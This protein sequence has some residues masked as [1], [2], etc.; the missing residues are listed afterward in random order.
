MGIKGIAIAT[1]S[2]QFIGMSYIIYKAYLTDLKQYLYL[3]CF[4]PKFN[5]IKELLIQGIPASLGMMMISLGIYIILYF[6]SMF[7]VFALAGYGTAIRF[8]QIFLLPILGLNAAVLSIAGQNFGAKNYERVEEVYNKALKYGCTIMFFAGILIYF[9]AETAVSLFTNDEEVIKY[10][11]T[12][13]QITALMEPIYPIFFI[14]NALLQGLKKATYV[15]F[16]SMFRMVILPL[17]TLSFLILYLKSSFDFVFWGLL[18]IN[19]IFGIF[20]FIFTKIVMK[21]EFNKIKYNKQT[22]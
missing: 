2:A 6:I 22:I 1:I 7:G 21:K 11:T 5:L 18:I 12:Y 20:L 9:S 16:L 17:I 13:L 19:W 14:S 10:G 4:F 15:M 3:E 8:E